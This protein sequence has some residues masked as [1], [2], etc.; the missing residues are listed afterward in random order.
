MTAEVLPAS[1]GPS[2]IQSGTS[3]NPA[4]VGCIEGGG[5][6]WSVL[7][8]RLSAVVL[9]VGVKSSFVETRCLLVV[10]R[11]ALVAVASRARDLQ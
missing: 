6:V 3:S 4:Y 5:G 1:V 8:T 10:I 11:T 2:P 7:I 9:A